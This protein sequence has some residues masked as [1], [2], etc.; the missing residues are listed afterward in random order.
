MCRFNSGFFFRHPLLQKYRYYWRVEPYVH[1]H[2][3]TLFDPF[4]VRINLPLYTFCFRAALY[5]VVI[6]WR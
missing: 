5:A 2:C 6:G 1:F 4:L 3:D